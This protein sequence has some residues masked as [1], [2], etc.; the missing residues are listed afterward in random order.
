MSGRINSMEICVAK[1]HDAKGFC[2]CD[3]STHFIFV[4]HFIIYGVTSITR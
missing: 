3:T 4:L 2:R 1:S